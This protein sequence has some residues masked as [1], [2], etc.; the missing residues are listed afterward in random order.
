MLPGTCVA[1]FGRFVE[2]GKRDI[3][4]HAKLDMEPFRKSISFA[5]L[6]LITMW[7]HD[8]PRISR[9]LQESYTL[10]EEGKVHAPKTIMELPY[11]EAGP[12]K[13]F[14]HPDMS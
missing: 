6:D 9:L 2:I 4:E 1:R 14:T 10:L 11:S 7:E 12:S 3:H 8:Q 5:S 13:V